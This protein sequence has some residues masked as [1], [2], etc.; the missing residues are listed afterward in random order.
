MNC[1]RWIC[2][3]LAALGLAL[4]S[5]MTATEPQPESPLLAQTKP[6]LRPPEPETKPVDASKA[7]TTTV[8][9]QEGGRD[10]VGAEA[11]TQTMIQASLPGAPHQRLVKLAGRYTTRS[12][13]RPQPNVPVT[14]SRGTA[15]LTSILDG[16]FLSEENTGT[17]MGQAV[18]GQRLFGYNNATQL[19]ESAW[20]YTLSTAILTMTGTSA[21]EGKTIEWSGIFDD[22]GRG[23]QAIRAVTR[24]IDDDHFVVEMYGFGEDRAEFVMLE[25]TYTRRK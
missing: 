1:L 18:A 12:K 14:E 22:P 20:V 7:K 17:N 4:G 16:R 19:Y 13:F 9:T 11:A 2:P 10:T 23:K 15:K 24:L 3:I 25:T 6:E 5:T 21:D 8:R